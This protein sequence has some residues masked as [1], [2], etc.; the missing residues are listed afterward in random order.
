MDFT[1]VVMAGG[2]GKRFSS[3][4]YK[5]LY[6]LNRIPMIQHVIDAFRSV[7]VN[8]VVVIGNSNIYESLVKLDGITEI[9][10][11][12]KPLG[13]F[14]AVWKCFSTLKTKYTLIVPADKPFIDPK[15]I[16]LMLESSCNCILGYND[17]SH[18]PILLN[19]DDMNLIKIIE[20]VDDNTLYEKHKIRTGGVYC[21][22][23]EELSCIT[24]D[25]IGNYNKQN[26]YYLTDV[27]PILSSKVK[28]ILV[29]KMSVSNINTFMDLENHSN[30]LNNSISEH[31][32]RVYGRLNLMGRHIDH[33]GGFNNS[34]QIN[35]YIDVKIVKSKSL[36]T[37]VKIHSKYGT[38]VYNLD[39]LDEIESNW[40]QYVVCVFK[41]LHNIID[42]L[43][44]YD[45]YVDGNIPA[46]S[47]LSSSSAVVVGTMKCLMKLNTLKV[48]D[49]D[50][51]LLSSKAERLMGTCGGAGD[52][53]ALV[54]GSLDKCIKFKSHPIIDVTDTIKLPENLRIQ[55]FHT[56]KKALKGGSEQKI[57]NR[58]VKC[59]NI[60]LNIIDKQ[61]L[62]DVTEDELKDITVINVKNVLLYGIR[63]MRRASEF[64][65]YLKEGN[66]EKI[67][68]L[69]RESQQDEQILYGCSCEEAD[70]IVDLAN[71]VDGV[72][73]AQIAGAG[74]GGCVMVFDNN[75]S[76]VATVLRNQGFKLI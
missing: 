20:D 51:V 44:R 26:E 15:N 25:D 28:I 54:M 3:S 71:S 74:L 57:F 29:N 32:E 35:K 14:H 17:T 18:K 16:K 76:D 52:H 62:E 34:I 40:S 60:G 46:G 43:Y 11:Q 66:L 9:V 50:I 13:T 45:V 8:K 12:D 33:Q 23:T 67:G 56:G 24:L 63:E 7:G 53:C 36:Y 38:E 64:S 70:K 2:T 65:N 37:L 47:G 68:K 21:F 69:V 41:Q 48:T 73:G 55:L 61:K 22:K 72:L 39:T 30:I 6:K 31:N 42:K 10:I 58:K 27:I 59:Y 19:D 5:Q 75:K 49:M 4:I 1:V